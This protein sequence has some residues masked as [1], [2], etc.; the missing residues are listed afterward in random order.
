MNS[1]MTNSIY[2]EQIAFRNL[3]PELAISMTYCFNCMFDDT[4]IVSTYLHLSYLEN[5]LG[6][7]KKVRLMRGRGSRT[8]RY[9]P[10]EKATTQTCK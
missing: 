2:D 3:K 5:S 7:K 8:L 4:E 10:L 1:C 9:S 6:K